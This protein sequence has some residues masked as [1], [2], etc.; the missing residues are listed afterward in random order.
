MVR[1]LSPGRGKV[2]EV[3]CVPGRGT[4]SPDDSAVT[5]LA[6]HG[7]SASSGVAHVL[8]KLG[9]VSVSLTCGPGLSG[10][11]RGCIS[12]PFLAT[13]LGFLCS[14]IIKA[15]FMVGSLIEDLS[16]TVP[17]LSSSGTLKPIAPET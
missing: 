7:C 17:S 4:Q 3:V 1:Q 16:T 9:I 13:F 11:G 2:R 12:E 15:A 10:N 14:R 5:Q 8:L 6:A